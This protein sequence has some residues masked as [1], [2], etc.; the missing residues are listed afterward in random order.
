MHLGRVSFENL[1]ST[2][3]R[4]VSIYHVRMIVTYAIIVFNMFSS[5]VLQGYNND[6]NNLQFEMISQPIWS[7]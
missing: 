5:S 1:L 7:C 4:L 6:Y 2:S 3:T